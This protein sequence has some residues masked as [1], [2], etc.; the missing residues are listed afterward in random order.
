M[1]QRVTIT[2]TAAPSKL[3]S[4]IQSTGRDAILRG[5]GKSD[6]AAVCILETHAQGIQDPVRGLIRMVQVS[7]TVLIVD[8]T[9][10]G[11]PS[12]KYIVNIHEAGD[13]SRG[14]ESVGKVY[15]GTRGELGYMGRVEVD[16]EGKGALLLKRT[17]K[18]WE[19]IG[20]S[21]VVSKDEGERTLEDTVLGVIA[22][23]AGV[24]D[25]D[26]TVRNSHFMK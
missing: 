15:E 21:I 25:N 9:L 26:K 2:G 5:T 3:V 17:A 24:W 13:I 7:P 20:R 19:L 10:K 16:E 6:S 4:A 12:G 18:L 8:L 14:A 1:D 22:R 23:S 11:L